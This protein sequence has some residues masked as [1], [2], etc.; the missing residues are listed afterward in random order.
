VVGIDGRP[1][2]D[3]DDVP[4]ESID[5]IVLNTLSIADA[6]FP[7]PSGNSVSR[8]VGAVSGGIDVV[9]AESTPRGALESVPLSSGVT[10]RASAEGVG[11]LSKTEF[12]IASG[13]SG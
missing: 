8:Q 4:P 6:D 7:S 2:A 9:G 5:S 1:S 11:P 10:S 12:C 3:G 13:A